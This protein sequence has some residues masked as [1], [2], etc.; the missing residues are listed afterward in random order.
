MFV[1]GTPVRGGLYGEHPS[2]EDLD[3]GGDLQFGTDFRA[4]YATVIEDGFG[5]GAE[6]VL[7][8]R[9]E[10]LPFLERRS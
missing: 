2:L 8:A 5:V 3:E 4:V 6:R 10:R 9:F 7:G 1:L